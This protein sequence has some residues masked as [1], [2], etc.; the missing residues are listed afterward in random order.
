MFVLALKFKYVFK[1]ATDVHVHFLLVVR[2]IEK[3]VLW[4]N[5]SNLS[6]KV[7]VILQWAAI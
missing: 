7:K 2:E 6:S 5:D 1:P 4:Q 3:N